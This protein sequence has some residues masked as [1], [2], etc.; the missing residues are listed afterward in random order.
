MKKIYRQGYDIGLAPLKNDIFHNSK[1]NNKFREYG[2]CGI[3]GIYSNSDVYANCVENGVTGI[4]VSNEEG[5]WYK[6]IFQMIDDVKLRRAIQRQARITIEKD[7]SLVTFSEVL[8]SDINLTI[9]DHLEKEIVGV[10]EI[11]KLKKTNDINKL[12]PKNLWL[13]ILNIINFVFG[14][15]SKLLKKYG[16][17]FT[18]RLTIVEIKNIFNISQFPIKLKWVIL[19]HSITRYLD[20]LRKDQ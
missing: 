20:C 16:L 19:Q 9:R 2:A 11:Q 4:L 10:A 17:L 13:K 7:Y 6:A 12:K 14:K 1:T 3:A 8:L 18:I 15:I 5:E